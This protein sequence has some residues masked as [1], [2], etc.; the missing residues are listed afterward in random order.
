MPLRLQQFL[1][2]LFTMLPA[3]LNIIITG[4][5]RKFLFAV[6]LLSYLIKISTQLNSQNAHETAICHNPPIQFYRWQK[7][8]LS[9]P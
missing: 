1:S 4:A 7:K 9:S 5:Q 6:Y 3:L 8:Y 2:T